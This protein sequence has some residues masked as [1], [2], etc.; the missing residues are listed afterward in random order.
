MIHA[1]VLEEPQVSGRPP[2]GSPLVKVGIYEY[3]K[4]IKIELGRHVV[5]LPVERTASVQPALAGRFNLG[6][7]LFLLFKK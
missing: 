3:L 2:E 6:F 7:S 1:V 4:E 5:R